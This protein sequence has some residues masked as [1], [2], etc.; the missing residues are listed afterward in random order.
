MPG[1]TTLSRDLSAFNQV[2]REVCYYCDLYTEKH[3]R[4]VVE[5]YGDFSSDQ[6]YRDFLRDIKVERWHRFHRLDCN[7]VP[8]PLRQK[9]E[10]IQLSPE[11]LEPAAPASSSEEDDE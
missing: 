10:Q 4:E 5:M 1:I 2:W 8:S 11:D 7:D 6:H 3:P 9:L